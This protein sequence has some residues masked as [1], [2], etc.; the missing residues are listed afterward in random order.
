MN[1]GYFG[2]AGGPMIG[3]AGAQ[4]GNS[5][6]GKQLA[7]MASAQSQNIF[8]ATLPQ[9]RPSTEIEE[10]LDRTSNA[11]ARLA[12]RIDALEDRLRPVVRQSGA[13]SAGSNAAPKA[14]MSP[15]G[16]QLGAFQNRIDGACDRLEALL[17]DLAL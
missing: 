14:V 6:L 10:G 9:D 2:D 5:H 8:H 4:C 3:Q 1:P 12:S 17:R 15:L 7:A 11:I 13:G 16:E